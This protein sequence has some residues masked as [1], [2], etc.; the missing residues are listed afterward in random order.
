MFPTKARKQHYSGFGAI[1][2]MMTMQAFPWCVWPGPRTALVFD[3]NPEF[4]RAWQMTL[5]EQQ[6]AGC[7]IG[8]DSPAPIVNHAL[9]REKTLRRYHR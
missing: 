6:A 7:I 1:S 9:A 4:F 5:L 8:K 2:E 3:N